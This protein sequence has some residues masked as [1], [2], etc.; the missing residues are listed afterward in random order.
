MAL[1]AAIYARISQK[2]DQVNKVDN[3]IA[4]MT[5]FALKQGYEVLEVFSDDDVSAYLGKYPRPGFD[6]LITRLTSKEFDVVLATEQSRFA[7]NSPRDLHALVTA[8][9]AGGVVIRTRSEGTFDPSNAGSK[10][11]LQILDAVSGFEVSQ[12]V[13][14]Q[15]ARNRAD[16]ALGLPTKGLRPFGWEKDRITLREEEAVYVREAVNSILNNGKTVWAIAQLWN[17]LG[18]KTDSM[19][20]PRKHRIDKVERVPKPVWTSTTVRMILTRPRNAGILISL[21]AEASKSQIQPIISRGQYNDLLAAIKGS[22][23]LI[24]PK[25][26]YLLGG[27]LE[28][29][30][31]ERM[32]ASKSQ[33]GRPGKKHDYKIYRCRLYGFDKTIGHATIQLHLA[34]NAV[35]D[36]IVENIGLGIEKPSSVGARELK[37]VNREFNKLIAEAERIQNLIIEGTGIVAPLK[38]K[39]RANRVKRDALDARREQIYAS[40]GHSAALRDFAQKMK[41]LPNDASP[42]AIDRALAEGYKAWDDL[43]MDD[44]RAII[45]GGYRVTLERGGRGIDRVHVEK[46]DNPLSI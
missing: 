37:K 33:S 38:G 39:L 18:I 27:I 45:R 42:K 3:Q 36:W 10:F 25:P 4:E 40:F 22:S 11:A 23:G 19:T 21:G 1:K 35:R 31:G 26:Q 7:R 28:C 29:P 34:D 46:I 32:T 13:E 30:C 12:R 43:P 15:K 9:T 2:D 14:R 16:T 17:E 8:A 6:E 24:G 5:E 44:R 41:K 20:R